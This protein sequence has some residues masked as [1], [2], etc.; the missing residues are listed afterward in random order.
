VSPVSENFSN[1]KAV[2]QVQVTN[3]QLTPMS[4]SLAWFQ[5]VVKDK[6]KVTLDTPEPGVEVKLPQSF[7]IEPRGSRIIDVSAS[8]PQGCNVEVSC[9]MGSP[10]MRVQNG[11]LLKIR[12]GSILYI[13]AANEN[14]KDQRAKILK[15]GGFNLE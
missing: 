12:I 1:G 11:V 4:V 8:C 2:T 7:K 13:A 14:G 3:N 15:A 6:Q 9:T 10:S 5:F